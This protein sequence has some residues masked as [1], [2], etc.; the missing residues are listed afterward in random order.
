MQHA[1]EQ[2]VGMVLPATTE[3]LK[4]VLPLYHQ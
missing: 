1:V 2:V 4:N 3:M